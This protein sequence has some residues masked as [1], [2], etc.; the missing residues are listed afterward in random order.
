MAPFSNS[1]GWVREA[2]PTISARSCLRTANLP[3]PQS[4]VAWCA[5]AKL[6]PVLPTREWGALEA[7]HVSVALG[8]ASSME[9]K[10]T[11]LLSHADNFTRLQASCGL[12]TR[13]C[14]AL[15]AV[16]ARKRM[17]VPG[18]HTYRR[19]HVPFTSSWYFMN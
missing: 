7:P 13:T 2:A 10:D 8:R 19:A 4:H 6:A 3:L 12:C 11:H 14:G 5:R 9:K 16:A 18:D 15:F 17:P 1:P